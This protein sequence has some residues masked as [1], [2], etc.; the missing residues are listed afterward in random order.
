MARFE[1]V[2]PRAR[3]NPGEI[4]RSAAFSKRRRLPSPEAVSGRLVGRGRQGARGI[5]T[6]GA[7]SQGRR[8]RPQGN[9]GGLLDQAAKIAD[10]WIREGVLVATVECRGREEKLAH[11]EANEPDYPL[12]VLVSGSSASASEI[13][14]GA[15]KNHDRAV[16]VGEP[17]FGKG[18]V[19]LV[20][21]DVTPTRPR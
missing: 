10:K 14:A 9:P 12:V 5:S 2:R 4:G 19:Q 6:E 20:F 17:T 1:A 11:V 18:S 8:S 15:L 21:P 16:L 13:V 7:E 3:A